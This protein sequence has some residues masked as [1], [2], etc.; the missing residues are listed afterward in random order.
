M[1]VRK[2]QLDVYSER[3]HPDVSCSA[4]LDLSILKALGKP[5]GSIPSSVSCVCL[6]CGANPVLWGD[7]ILILLIHVGFM[8]VHAHGL[9]SDICP[10]NLV[11]QILLESTLSLLLFIPSLSIATPKLEDFTWRA[12]MA[13]R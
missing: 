6:F 8:V 2:D 7:A 5:A 10:P 11:P 1:N 3:A 12:E 9:L 4:L 13:R